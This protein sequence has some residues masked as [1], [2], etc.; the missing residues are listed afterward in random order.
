MR[1]ALILRAGEPPE[2]PK[3]PNWQRR[4]QLAGA[5]AQ[6]REATSSTIACSR[7]AAVARRE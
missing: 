5:G 1:V 2:C 6:P 4:C 7:R 3:S